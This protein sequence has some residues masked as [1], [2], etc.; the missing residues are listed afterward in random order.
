MTPAMRKRLEAT[1]GPIL[2]AQRFVCQEPMEM[3]CT[4]CNKVLQLREKGQ[5]GF[6]ELTDRCDCSWGC[7]QPAGKIHKSHMA[8]R[9]RSN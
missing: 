3:Y 5:C 2:S 9:P 4:C 8:Y 6:H 1:F 7:C